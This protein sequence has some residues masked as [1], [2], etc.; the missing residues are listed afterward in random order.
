VEKEVFQKNEI[1]AILNNMRLKHLGVMINEKQYNLSIN[2][3]ITR[4][5]PNSVNVFYDK[6]PDII[7]FK[8]LR[9]C[10]DY[11][12]NFYNSSET[13]L[14]SINIQLKSIELQIPEKFSY[15]Q[16]RKFARINNIEQIELN[17]R[18]I[19]T[20]I[21]DSSQNINVD[22]LPATLR[23]IY[24]ELQ[25]ETPDIKKIISM[26]GDEL[27]RYS[28]RFK[29][30]LF[31]D[32]ST[33][34]PIERVVNMYKKTFWIGD[35]DNLNNYIHVGDK[36]SI[37]GYEKYFDMIKKTMSP[38]ILEQI[39]QNYV[40]RDISSYSMVPIIVGDR[41]VGVIEV[42]VPMDPKY[43]KL[44][45]YE[46]FYIKGLADILGEVVVKSQGISTPANAN[47]KVEDIS[48]GGILAS[49]KNMY[50]THTV[51]ENTVLILN[52]NSGDSL[53]D[54]RARVVRYEYLA[55][56]NAGLNV[57]FEFLIDDEQKKQEL[58]QIVK[59]F[60]TS[61]QDKKKIK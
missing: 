54:V 24:M 25:V 15:H 3:F 12:R 17:I 51:K 31:K 39:R 32:M 9:I 57:A 33:L 5:D 38:D 61:Q 43:K 55:G 34:S 2:G 48:A 46:I 37:I 28:N 30:N 21:V 52:I 42:S 18:K 23:N 27:G 60:V 13:M 49:T 29:I 4:A 10:F 20:G 59:K 36:Y 7:P 44:T 19:E 1:V 53:L 16:I 50:L 35:T 26:I 41:V 47:F 14:K 8:N 58:G 11:N 6:T 22:E 56:E 40:N 45:I